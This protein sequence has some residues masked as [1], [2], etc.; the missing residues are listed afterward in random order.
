MRR[1]E[2]RTNRIEA[3]VWLCRWIRCG[4]QLFAHNACWHTHWL[5]AF[6]S[7]RFCFKFKLPVAD[8]SSV[9]ERND[10]HGE[11]MQLNRWATKFDFI[12]DNSGEDN[13]M[14]ILSKW[15]RNRKFGLHRMTAMEMKRIFR[16]SR[17]FVVIFVIFLN[18][19]TRVC[20]DEFLKEE[21]SP[22]HSRDSLEITQEASYASAFSFI[23]QKAIWSSIFSIIDSSQVK[24]LSL[25]TT[26][27]YSPEEQ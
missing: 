16:V 15:R 4:Y 6:L 13:S 7:F 21:E 20:S 18:E 17:D 23:N 8:I 12:I 3:D 25:R 26:H 24:Q 14:S 27:D 5:P 2:P 22:Q 10:I 9:L 1:F 11:I 19:S